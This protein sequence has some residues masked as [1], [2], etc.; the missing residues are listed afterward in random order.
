MM[1]KL[2]ESG[3][4]EFSVAVFHC[5]GTHSYLKRWV[6]RQ[7]ALTIAMILANRAGST[8]D[9]VIITDG[10]D[11]TVFCWEHGKGIT[12]PDREAS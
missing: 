1:V 3:R 2:N 9:R 11:D 12:W 4:D 8:F 7:E 10:G 6:S 5:D